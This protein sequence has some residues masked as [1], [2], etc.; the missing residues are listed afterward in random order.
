MQ[1]GESAGPECKA[2][3]QEITQL[4]EQKLASSGSKVKATFDAEDVC[5]VLLLHFPCKSIL[6]FAT[7]HEYFAH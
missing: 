5:F 2:V 4:V 7:G 3:L 6:Y 1:V